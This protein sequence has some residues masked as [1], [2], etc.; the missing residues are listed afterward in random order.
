MAIAILHGHPH[1]SATGRVRIA[2]ELKGV[3]YDLRVLDL[4]RSEHR[5]PPYTTALNP[6]GQVPTLEIDG[7]RLTQ[8]VAILEYLEETRPEP[9]LLPWT[10]AERAS[11]R[12]IVEIVNAGIQPL[13]NSGVLLEIRARYRDETALTAIER[14]ALGDDAVPPSDGWA[15]HFIRKGLAALGTLLEQ[16]AGRFCIGDRITLADVVL[17]PQVRAT[18]AYGVPLTDF[19]T[20]DR[21]AR[22][23]ERRPAFA[24]GLA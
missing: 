24:A 9:R 15:Q 3:A 8:S 4:V 12:Q 18:R 11:C 7:L 2:L 21:I 23:L 1:S 17:A 14:A 5:E 16:T 19:P 6:L 22:A 10:P 13:Q 20:I